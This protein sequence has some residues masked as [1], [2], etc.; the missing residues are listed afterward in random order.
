MI[1]AREPSDSCQ[2]TQSRGFEF[3]ACNRICLTAGG[4]SDKNADG[5]GHCHSNER[6]AATSSRDS[7]PEGATVSLRSAPSLHNQSR[8]AGFEGPIGDL[9]S[10]IE[11]LERTYSRS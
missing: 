9:K 6:C 11:S 4:H 10:R 7:V 5:Q 3:S 2:E 8:R 1:H